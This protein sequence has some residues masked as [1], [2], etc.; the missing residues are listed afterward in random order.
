MSVRLKIYGSATAAGRAVSG[1]GGSM[2]AAAG[3]GLQSAVALNA[4]VSHY[5]R[6][7][8][9]NVLGCECHC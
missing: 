6:H 5:G 4:V 2:S 1:E 7:G 9:G 8:I 3:L